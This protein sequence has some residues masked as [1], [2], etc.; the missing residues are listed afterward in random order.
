MEG[1]VEC[2]LFDA[3]TLQQKCAELGQEISKDYSGKVPLLVGVL[4][5]AAVF[6]SDLIRCVSIPAEIDFISVSSYGK[7]AVSGELRFRKDLEQDLT[8]RHVILV[9][10]IVDTGK[11][12][13]AVTAAFASRG[14]ASVEI[15]TLLDKKAHRAVE[16][17]LK[18]VGFDCPDEFVIG[19]GIDYAERYRTLPYVAALKRS[20]YE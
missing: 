10:D 11:T 18:Y 19:Y 17:N 6:M 4:S 13:K 1:D 14:A 3:Q 16:L 7:E 12:L 9:E 5:G 2:V 15:C 8:G 20:V